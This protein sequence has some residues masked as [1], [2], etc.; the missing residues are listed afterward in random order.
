MDGKTAAAASIDDYIAAQAG[1]VQPIL[2]RIRAIVR[3]EA[4][5]AQETISYRMPALRLG[6]VLLYF[7]AFKKHIGIYPPVRGDAALL[8][9]LAPYR[10][11]KGNLSFPLAEAMPY[12]LIRRVARQRVKESTSKALGRGGK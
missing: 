5:A 1:G 11:E 6:G 8:R 7:A 9:A 2:Q 4:P 12:E 10:G 3:E